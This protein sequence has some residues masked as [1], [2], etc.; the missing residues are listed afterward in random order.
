MKNMKISRRKEILQ[1]VSNG[2]IPVH[3][4]DIF[5]PEVKDVVG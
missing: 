2:S 3:V 1:I 4:D 5:E